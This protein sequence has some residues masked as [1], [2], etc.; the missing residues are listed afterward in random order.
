MHITEVYAEANFTCSSIINPY[1]WTVLPIKIKEKQHTQGGVWSL[2]HYHDRRDNT[3]ADSGKYSHN[4]YNRSNKVANITK[5]Y[6]S[7][8]Y[9]AIY[10]QYQLVGVSDRDH[11]WKNLKQAKE[12]VISVDYFSLMINYTTPL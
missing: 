2:Y 1:I 11:P 5:A 6:S 10:L 7:Y 3:L 8:R 12:W 4:A 9:K